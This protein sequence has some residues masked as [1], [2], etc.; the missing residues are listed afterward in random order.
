MVTA[1]C[2][3]KPDF[4][5]RWRSVGLE[6]VWST[7]GPVQFVTRL[8]LRTSKSLKSWPEVSIKNRGPDT[9]QK[10]AKM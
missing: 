2:R 5:V 3:I 4:K 7:S 1:V 10:A 8:F 9:S 6:R